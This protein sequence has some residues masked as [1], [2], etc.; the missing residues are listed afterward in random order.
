MSIILTKELKGNCENVW[1]NFLCNF[2][3]EDKINNAYPIL[4]NLG[5]KSSWVQRK[6]KNSICIVRNY[7]L[8]RLQ[9]QNYEQFSK[10]TK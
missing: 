4:I 6:T 8:S 9:T 1:L 2:T 3:P 10:S 5:V 7:D